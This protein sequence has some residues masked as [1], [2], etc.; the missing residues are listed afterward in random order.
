[1]VS[2]RAGDSATGFIRWKRTFEDGSP[3]RVRSYVVRY[4]NIHVNDEGMQEGWVA[5]MLESDTGGPLP[6]ESVWFVGRYV[7]GGQPGSVGDEY[8][9]SP[10]GQDEATARNAVENWAAEGLA[11]WRNTVIETGNLEVRS[12]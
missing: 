7:D 9:Y 11:A 6:P 3:T 5:A 2:V 8:H 4:A 1:V 10:E 12:F